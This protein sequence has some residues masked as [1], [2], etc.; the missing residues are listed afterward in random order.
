MQAEIVVDN[1]LNTI[2]GRSLSRIYTPSVFIEGAIKLTL[3]KS[4]RV[5]YGMG[6]DGSDVLIPQ[7]GDLS[8]DLGIKRA[9]A[10]FGADIKLTGNPKV[11][12]GVC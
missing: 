2:S 3:G 12:E 1:I 9:W 8:L 5:I 10:Q 7:K 11:S 4:H 6:E